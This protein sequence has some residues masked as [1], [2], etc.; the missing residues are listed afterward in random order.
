MESPFGVNFDT[1]HEP[2]VEV[3]TKMQPNSK[4]TIHCAV[5]SSE[6][7]GV[8]DRYLILAENLKMCGRCKQI[9]YC[10]RECQTKHW[11]YHK[12]QCKH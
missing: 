9:S 11:K 10:S 4:S 2:Q 6:G 8:D 12:T 1:R 3:D 5:C 7:K